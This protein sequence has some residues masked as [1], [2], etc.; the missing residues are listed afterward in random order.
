[1]DVLYPFLLAQD[2]ESANWFISILQT[3]LDGGVPLICLAFAGLFGW[4][5][6][7]QL[8]RNNDL[9]REFREKN[10]TNANAEM[11]RQESLLREMLNRDKEATETTSAAIQAVESYSHALK[12][13]QLAFDGLKLAHEAQGRETRELR[14]KV[15]SLEET[16]RR[17]PGA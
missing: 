12:E 15:V 11:T 9:E 3:I 1:M 17:F 6:W 7:K 4:A 2:S 16:V 5:Y 13:Q 8:Q 14:D 10:E